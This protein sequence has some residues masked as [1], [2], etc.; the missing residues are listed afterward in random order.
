MTCGSD[1]WGFNR[2]R[3]WPIPLS[4]DPQSFQQECVCVWVGGGTLCPW[5]SAAWFVSSWRFRLWIW[6]TGLVGEWT[7]QWLCLKYLLS[8]TYQVVFLGAVLFFVYFSKW[9]CIMITQLRS[10]KNNVVLNK[11]LLVRNVVILWTYSRTDIDLS[12]KLYRKFINGK[13]R[14]NNLLRIWFISIYFYGL[15][16][17]FYKYINLCWSIYTHTANVDNL[18]VHRSSKYFKVLGWSQNCTFLVTS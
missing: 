5:I 10:L 11:V 16:L 2:A 9:L 8:T 12:K 6:K 17:I 7:W 13:L 18:C 3:T 4:S 1:Y 14:W 15:K